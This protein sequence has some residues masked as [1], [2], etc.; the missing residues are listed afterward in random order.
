[1][2]NLS[3]YLIIHQYLFT[4]VYHSSAMKRLNRNATCF[5]LALFK[6]PNKHG[7]YQVDI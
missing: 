5:N 6:E 3:L 2:I 1:M 7:A 4:G